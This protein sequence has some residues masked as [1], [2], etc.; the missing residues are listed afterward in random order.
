MTFFKYFLVGGFSA[1][2]NLT[3]FF[4]LLRLLSVNYLAAA[5]VSF[6]LATLVNYWI[7]VRFVFRSG[8]RF[9]KH[10][11][12][13]WIFVV[14][15]IGLLLNQLILFVLVSWCRWPPFWSQ[16]VSLASIFAWNFLGRRYFI[17]K[18]LR[19]PAGCEPLVPGVSSTPDTQTSQSRP[20]AG[21][22]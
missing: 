18:A 7:S 20:G 2:V 9:R 5:T 14:S 15:V 19:S 10:G 6:I 12:M 21:L 1:L 4:V 22:R 3:L 13:F 8:V 16:V 11:E 17:F